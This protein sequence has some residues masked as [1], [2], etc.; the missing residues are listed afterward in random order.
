MLFTL[1]ALSFKP[2][3][4]KYMYFVYMYGHN[5]AY[6]FHGSVCLKCFLK[7]NLISLICFG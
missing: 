5:L 4:T 2:Q 3:S 7:Q 1:G 6:I